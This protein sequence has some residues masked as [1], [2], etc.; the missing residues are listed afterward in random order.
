MVLLVTS[1]RS[2]VEEF[3]PLGQMMLLC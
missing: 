2:F 1:C 3:S